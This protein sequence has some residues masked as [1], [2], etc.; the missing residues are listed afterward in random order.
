MISCV[1]FA[2]CWHNTVDRDRTPWKMRTNGS[3]PGCSREDS[4]FP[5]YVSRYGV[6]VLYSRLPAYF[7]G[8]QLRMA[9]CSWRICPPYRL[10]MSF[11]IG[12]KHH[13]RRHSRHQTPTGFRHCEPHWLKA[14][15]RWPYTQSR[16]NTRNPSHT[17]AAVKQILHERIHQRNESSPSR[18]LIRQGLRGAG[19]CVAKIEL[20]TAA[21]SSRHARQK[22]NYMVNGA[23]TFKIIRHT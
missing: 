22:A 10:P 18:P 20:K 1:R 11:A 2:A 12:A 7:G 21:I 9:H 8:L 16:A 5:A 14:A 4:H 19:H 23:Q 15:Q 3:G 6:I 17:F 13:P